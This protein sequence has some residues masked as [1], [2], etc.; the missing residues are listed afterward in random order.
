MQLS[1]IIPTLD[2][3]GCVA[4]AIRRAREAGPTEI[5][6]ADGGSGDRTPQRAEAA[7][8]DIVLA[9]GR[10]RAFQQNTA[11]AASRGDALLFLHADCW[12]EPGSLE[13]IRAALADE[14]VVGGCFRQRIEAPGVLYR[15]LERGNSL[16]VRLF[17]WAYG[18]QGIFVR[19]EAFESIGGFPHVQMMEDLLLMKRLKRIGKVVLLNATIHVSPRRW[20]KAGIVRQTLKNWTLIA[21]VQCGV[22]PDRL[23]RFYHPVR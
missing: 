23:A 20:Q 4:D 15:L 18:D 1:I 13:A 3:A 8:A 6:V 14:R 22:S 21:L 16:R 10:G 19:R 11:A 5:I 12:I 7:G 17:G 9:T 2:E